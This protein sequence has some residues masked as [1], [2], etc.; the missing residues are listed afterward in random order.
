MELS[1]I[2]IVNFRSFEDETI[3]LDDYNCF[4]GPNGSGKSTILTAL[5]ILFRNSQ[6][7]FDVT[8]LYE[9]DF[10]LKNTSKPITISATFSNLSTE[11]EADFGAYVRHGQLVIIAKAE[12]DENI[13]RAIV[14][15]VG[16]R[17]VMKEFAPYFEAMD[18]KAKAVELKGIYAGYREKYTELPKVSSMGDM[19]D[20]LRSYEES[21]PEKCELIES[22]NQFYGWSK[23]ANRLEKYC[24]WIYIP[25][26]KDAAQEQDES[27]TSALG[28]ILQRT[29]RSKVDFKE[30]IDGIKSELE[31]KYKKI[32]DD[33]QSMLSDMAASIQGRLQEWAHPGAKVELLWHYDDQKSINVAEPYARVK[34]GEGS[35]LGD[36]IRLGHGMQRSFLVALLQELATSDGEQQPKLIL[37][38]EEP[39]LYQ[40]PPQARHLSTVLELLS[41]KDA[42]VLITTHSPY[43]VSGK[44]FESVRMT[45]NV[46]EKGSTA[47]KQMTSKKLSESLSNA[48]GTA[49]TIPSAVM[50]AVEQIMQPSQNELYFSQVPILVEGL[51]DV[52]FISTYL[53]LS[54]R[55]SEFRQNGCHF[56][57]C[58]GKNTLSRP[59]AIALGLK[60]PVFVVFDGD[61][62]KADATK[63]NDQHVRDNSCIQALCS[64]TPEPIVEKTLWTDRLVMWERDLMHVVKTDVG[65]DNWGSSIQEVRDVYGLSSDVSK[66]NGLLISA[67]IENLW[68]K[69]IK[70]ESLEQLCENIIKWAKASN[71]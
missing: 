9:E 42:Q 3:S 28:K 12:W 41:S 34:I 46:G 14:K 49:P 21:N 36:V 58:G 66:K 13:E 16:S 22:P 30:S 67:V 40:H 10:H 69:E 38:F 29:I 68:G 23:G 51:E 1:Q 62:N 26:V 52:A 54:G 63:K 53:Q 43:F 20:A 32:L 59:L 27:K 47:V 35:F 57:V 8:D 18:A 25:A 5:N 60:M 11:A 65:E 2:R 45:R 4:V 61:C 56:I 15:Q 70:S 17:L 33:E 39:E 48:L 7:A 50:A 37:G 19:R 71:V 44:G 55:W 24:Q 31:K 6:V 64:I